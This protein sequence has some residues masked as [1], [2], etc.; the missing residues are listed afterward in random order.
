VCVCACERACV[1][2]VWC[3]CVCVCVCGV[4]RVHHPACCASFIALSVDFESEV[5]TT[6]PETGSFA[7]EFCLGA[8]C[9]AVMEV[10]AGAGS[11]LSTFLTFF[12]TARISEDIVASVFVLLHQ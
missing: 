5:A 10:R 6:F 9:V 3:V 11:S 8:E 4:W 1:P 2:Y 12:M 7:N